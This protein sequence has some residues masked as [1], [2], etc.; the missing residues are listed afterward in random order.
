MDSTSNFDAWLEQN[1]VEGHEEIYALHQALEG[2]KTFGNFEV[3]RDGE[4]TFIKGPASILVLA[5][6]K[7]RVAF[8]KT[9]EQLKGDDDLDM[10]SWYSFKRS[11]ADPKA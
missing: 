9:V 10:D 4:K 11:M 5:T 1:D 7:A 3:T 2:R 6:N 8:L